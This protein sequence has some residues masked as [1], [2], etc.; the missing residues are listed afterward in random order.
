MRFCVLVIP[1]RHHCGAG[2]LLGATPL[3]SSGFLPPESCITRFSMSIK[4]SVTWLSMFV[5]F[6]VAQLSMLAEFSVT[7][8]FVLAKFPV[9]QTSVLAT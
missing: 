2:L 5:E 4:F 6:F 1:L 9:T 7:R 8:F 3:P